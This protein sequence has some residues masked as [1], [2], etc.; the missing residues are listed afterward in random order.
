MYSFERQDFKVKFGF[1]GKFHTHG[2]FTGLRF[3]FIKNYRPKGPICKF[4]VVDPSTQVKL[5]PS[6]MHP[7]QQVSGS[8]CNQVPF[9]ENV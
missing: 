6:T 7:S 5:K 8:F 4:I 3:T 1:Y 2:F 9:V